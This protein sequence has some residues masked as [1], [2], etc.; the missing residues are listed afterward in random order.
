[1]AAGRQTTARGRDNNREE[2]GAGEGRPKARWA[3]TARRVTQAPNTQGVPNT[4][5]IRSS[6]S[7]LLAGSLLVLAA[8]TAAPGATPNPTP[9]ATPDPTPGTLQPIEVSYDF[10]RGGHEW[11]AD[12]TDYTK[13]VHEG[14][15]FHSELE[16]RGY[17]LYGRNVS[18]D[19]FMY[20][21][22]LLTA[23]EGIVAG[24]EYRL[25]YKV[26][27]LSDGPTGC[28][29]IGGAPG[30]SV[31]LKLGGSPI[32]PVPTED[33][34]DVWLSVDKGNQMQGGPAGSNAGDIANGIDCEDAIVHDPMPLAQVVREHVHD[35]NVTASDQGELWLLVGTDSGF[36]G[37]TTIVYESIEVSLEPV[38]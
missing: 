23:E 16:D 1:V 10:T 2:P 30:E 14:I 37:A 21:R 38:G 33:G 5:R 29:G 24:Q 9:G 28:M 31:I 8:C 26:T 35:T 19:L 4:M 27:F 12:Y 3:C 36:E 32:E 15:R 17:L 34:E 13:P 22:R 18:D 20:I 7:P 6:R 25:T 11:K